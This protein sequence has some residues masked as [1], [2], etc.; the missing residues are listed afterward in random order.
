MSLLFLLLVMADADAALARALSLASA[1]KLNEAERILVEGRKAYPLDARFDVELAG[2]AWRNKQTERAK[3]FL[4]KG[5]RLDPSNAYANEFL[6]TA[7]LLDG[8]VFA[9]LPYLNRLRRPVIGKVALAPDPP[10]RTE[11]I[12]R[13]VGV[14]TGQLLTTRRLSETERNLARLRMF[15]EPRFQLAPVGSSYDLTVRAPVLSQ[16]LSGVIGRV[17]PIVR[18]LPYQQVNFDWLNL[19]HRAI[20][21]TSQW[22]WDPDKRRIAVNYRVPSIH[23]AYSLWTDLRDEE[24]NLPMRNDVGIRSAAVGGAL[25]FELGNGLTWTPGIVLSRHTFRHGAFENATIAEIRNRFDLPRWRFAERRVTVDS[26]VTA[27]AGRIFSGAGSRLVGAEFDTNLRWLPQAKDDVYQVSGR[28]RAAAL[29]GDLP[30]DALY[31][32]AIERD[33]DL[34]LRGHAGTQNG[35]KGNAPMGSRF[36]VMQTEFTR[37]VL[38]IPFVRLDAGPFFDVGNVGGVAGLGSRGFLYDTGLQANVSA[39]GG[40]RF[41]FVYGRDL[42]GGH[43]VFYATAILR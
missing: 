4:R 36:G 40:F 38:R 19:Q 7:Y 9:A 13:L 26:S 11:M 29:S 28:L 21:L 1:N 39:L 30:V 43:N 18:G 12:G 23:S 25:E 41:S 24:W 2:I 42:R 8:N 31:I 32:T 14:S 37:R 33:T 34:W 22:R 6:G 3:S 5:L 17:L 15:P 27:R 35:R 10:L 20:S 16:P